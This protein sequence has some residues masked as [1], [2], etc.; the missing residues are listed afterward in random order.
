MNDRG[1]KAWTYLQEI[2]G[3]EENSYK[4]WTMV[5]E[6]MDR[7]VDQKVNGQVVERLIRPIRRLENMIKGSLGLKLRVDFGKRD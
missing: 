5:V 1:L 2:R 4:Y 7:K 3:L 6:D